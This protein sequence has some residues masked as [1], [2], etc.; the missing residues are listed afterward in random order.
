MSEC[1]KRKDNL[2]FIEHCRRRHRQ[3]P[4]N[5]AVQSSDTEMILIEIGCHRKLNSLHLINLLIIAI[6]L[7]YQISH[8]NV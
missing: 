7:Q 3:I 4:S 8:Q 5:L 1:Q 2:L 6:E